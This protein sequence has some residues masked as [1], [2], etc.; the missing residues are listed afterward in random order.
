LHCYFFIGFISESKS[1]AQQELEQPNLRFYLS[2][3]KSSFAGAI[4][5]NQVWTRRIWNNP[6]ALAKGMG[7]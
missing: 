6:D 5:V 4:F 7:C 1:L 3:D 2:E